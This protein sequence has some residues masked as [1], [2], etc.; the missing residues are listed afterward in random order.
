MYLPILT[1]AKFVLHGDHKPLEP[2]LPKGMNIPKLDRW[3]MEL[4]DYYL[5]FIPIKDKKQCIDRYYLQV[6]NVKYL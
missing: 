1:G 6:G 3:S 5:T 2:F 4:A